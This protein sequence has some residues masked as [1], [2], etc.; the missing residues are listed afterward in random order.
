MKKVV[1][2]TYGEYWVDMVQL[3]II[4]CIWC[5]ATSFGSTPTW[6]TYAHTISSRHESEYVYY[7]LSGT[8]SLHLNM[9]LLL[10]IQ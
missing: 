10:T 3:I 7:G 4:K 9:L 1:F 5:L 8:R 6:S 2:K